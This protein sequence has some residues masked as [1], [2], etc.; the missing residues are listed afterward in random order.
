LSW[1]ACSRL[2]WVLAALA[3]PASTTLPELS[4]VAAA[5]ASHGPASAVDGS[6]STYW[7][8][9]VPT[10][11]GEAALRAALTG[12]GGAPVPEALAQAAEREPGS[13]AAGLARLAAAWLLVEAERAAEALPLLAH[14]DVA[15]TALGDHAHFVLGRALDAGADRAAAATA[16]RNAAALAAGR[17]LA[18]TALMRAAEALAAEEQTDDAVAAYEES[19]STCNRQQA[20]ALLRMAEFRDAQGDARAAAAAYD[21]LDREYPASPQALSAAARRRA[22]G[23]LLPAASAGERAE[24]EARRALALFAAGRYADA[25]R[26]LAAALASA[27]KKGEQTDLL[28]VRYGRALLARKRTRQGLAALLRVPAGSPHAGEA[29]YYA[30]RAQARPAARLAALDDVATRFRG[31]PWGED[32]LLSLATHYQKDALDNE[33]LPFYRRLVEEY[34]EGRYA[35]RSAWRTGWGDFRAGR[36]DDAA[37][38]FEWAARTRAVTYFTPGFLYWA[39]R[40]RQ[41]LGQVERARALYA[42]AVQR[43]K[44]AYHGLRAGEALAGLGGPPPP[45]PALVARDKSLADE[46]AEPQLTRLRQLLLIE[47]FD[48]ALDELRILPS[49]PAVDATIARLQWRLGR[50][51]PAINAMKRAFPGHVG[52]AGDRLPED[53]WRVLYPLGYRTEIETAAAAAGLDPSLL[54]ALIC[55]ESTFAADALS[56]AGAR[57]LMQV[58]PATGRAVAR[59]L[60]MKYRLS[61]LTDP[62][63]SLDL[64]AAY[65]R[66]MLERF[67]GETALALAAYNAGPHRVVA[68]TAGRPDI[69]VEEFVESIPFTETR[70]YVMNI[71]AAREQYRRLYGLQPPSSALASAPARESAARP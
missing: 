38:V 65:L 1:R 10:T 4:S 30:A 5:R 45:A 9:P 44:R 16:Y 18:C 63:T 61:A 43:F 20:H 70:N 15:R 67:G 35:D 53:V 2:V 31:T 27:P 26:A 36:F 25:E 14:P 48:E 3:P 52:S 32:A 66:R 8:E 34:P 47:R 13:A 59:D 6:A 24:R 51:R 49:A 62:R 54:A 12:A 7:L 23:G 42:E 19:L 39:G 21:R 33:A 37:R 69:G 64:G 56:P 58:M 29:A 22:L 68:W 11:P 41:Q 28:R 60:G 55:Q 46:I 40:A 50:L 57:G 17:P 71:L